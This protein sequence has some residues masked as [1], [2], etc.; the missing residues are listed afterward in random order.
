M[1]K[2]LRSV[3]PQR[4][5][6]S[7]HRM[8]LILWYDGEGEIE[9]FQLCYDKLRRERA[10]TWTRHGGFL[11]HRVDDGEKTPFSY[12]QT[13]ILVEDGLFDGAT[14]SEEFLARARELPDDLRQLVVDRIAGFSVAQEPPL[15]PSP[16]STGKP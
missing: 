4:R 15:Q 16:K 6:F 11:H 2:E 3:K 9:G 13:P 5:W 14:L 1:L 10:L 8:D 7:D 12:K